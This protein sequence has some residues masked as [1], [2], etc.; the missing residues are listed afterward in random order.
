MTGVLLLGLLFRE[1]Q[2]P[3]GIGRES[4]LL[5]AMYIAAIAMQAVVG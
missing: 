1:K 4:V 2:G 5:L 3:G